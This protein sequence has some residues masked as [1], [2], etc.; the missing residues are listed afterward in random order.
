MGLVGGLLASI[1][2]A[3]ETCLMP[4][5]AFLARPVTW[6]EAITHCEARL[7][8][9]PTFAYSLC[10]R[11][12]P[13]K[14]LEDVDLSSLRLAYVGAE[15][16]DPMT[17][18]AF[19]ERFTP[20]GLSPTAMYPVYGLA[21]A[22]LAVSFPAPGTKLRYDTVD[23]RRL[24]KAGVAELATSAG[25]DRATFV[26]VGHALPRHRV[27]IVDRDTGDPLAERQVGELLVEGDS[28]TP[29]Y[30]GDAPETICPV[31]HTGDLAYAADGHL[32]IV[33]RIKDLVIIG[34]QN[35]APSDIE[36]AAAEVV[37]LRRGRIVAF[38]APR[39]EGGEALHIVAEASPLRWRP[40]KEVEADVRK[41]VRR[42]IGLSAA[43]VTIVAPGSLERTSSGKIKRR[44]CAEAHR[45]GALA[46]L[47]TRAE[48]LSYWLARRSNVLL[49]SV[50][51]ALQLVFG[52]S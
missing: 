48:F 51:R 22:T 32:Y 47:S 2:C 24:A 42:A 17:L 3:A 41:A 37:G 28:V 40:L 1:Y 18:N 8:V 44:A 25:P 7:T 29:G 5:L 4:P 45:S 39:S 33:D 50:R 46:V 36:N 30:F 34:G 49:L 9:A 10:A 19:I 13:D 38:S 14:Q 12:I 43:T 27:T 35:Y 15:P 31:L 21:E 16:T 26:S 6:L 11:K 23:R 52:G 20:Y